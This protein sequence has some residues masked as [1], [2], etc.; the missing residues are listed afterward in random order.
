MD[1]TAPP[2]TDLGVWSEAAAER[3]ANTRLVVDFSTSAIVRTPA[4][5]ELAVLA[6]APRRVPSWHIAA[7]AASSPADAATGADLGRRC[8]RSALTT[9]PHLDGAQSPNTDEVL[10]HVTGS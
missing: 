8:W 5:E 6:G 1:V 3:P 10:S 2:T 4:A 9:R 7:S